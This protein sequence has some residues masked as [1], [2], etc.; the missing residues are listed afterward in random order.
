VLLDDGVVAGVAGD[1]AAELAG[2]GGG[3]EALS[4]PW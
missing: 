2:A 1:G 4:S 3:V